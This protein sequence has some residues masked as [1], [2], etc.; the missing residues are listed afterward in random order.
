MSDCSSGLGEEYYF[1]QVAGAASFDC[2]LACMG[3]PTCPTDSYWSPD[4][5]L[6]QAAW[7]VNMQ[8]LC[9]CGEGDFPLKCGNSETCSPAAPEEGFDAVCS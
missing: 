8:G 9:M 1:E 7:D 4:A 3:F 6:D 2:N 5:S